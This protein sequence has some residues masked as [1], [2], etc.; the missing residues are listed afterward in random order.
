MFV[1]PLGLGSSI[2]HRKIAQR[3]AIH[4]IQIKEEQRGSVTASPYRSR[5]MAKERG[6]GR[7]KSLLL[8][9]PLLDRRVS[10][11]RRD[12]TTH[13]PPPAPSPKTHT[14]TQTHTDT[15]NPVSAHWYTKRKRVKQ[16]ESEEGE[17]ERERDCSS[18]TFGGE[19]SLGIS[20]SSAF[21]PQ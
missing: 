13:R 18:L 12:S 15:N 4:E 14:H 2:R 8:A 9:D 16:E 6:K 21:K 7:G 20:F 10:A 17:G 1:G 3:T 5:G 19:G 11:S